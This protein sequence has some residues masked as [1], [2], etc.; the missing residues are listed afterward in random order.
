M[1]VSPSDK[2]RQVELFVYLLCLSKCFLTCSFI[3]LLISCDSF[4]VF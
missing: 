3:L 1:C 4:V 2:N